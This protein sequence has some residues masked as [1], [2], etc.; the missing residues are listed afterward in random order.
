MLHLNQ[1]PDC[2]DNIAQ[3]ATMGSILPYSVYAL[4]NPRNLVSYLWDLLL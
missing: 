2:V 3:T 4:F 1:K